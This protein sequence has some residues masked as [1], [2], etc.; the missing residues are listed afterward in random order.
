MSTT[1]RLSAA[2]FRGTVDG[3][4]LSPPRRDD[5]GEPGDPGPAVAAHA[6]D[7][8]PLASPPRPAPVKA[9]PA[10]SRPRSSATGPTR[11]AAAIG[12]RA[13][14]HTAWRNVTEDAKRCAAAAARLDERSGELAASVARLLATG[15]EP[16]KV[17]ALL[18][19]LNIALEDMPDGLAELFTG[20]GS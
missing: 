20:S 5:A 18:L 14:D 16:M 3:P 9:S 8:P 4:H 7:T 17:A 6:P 12:P 15:A 1:G 10:R 13:G 19:S 2:Q 11:P